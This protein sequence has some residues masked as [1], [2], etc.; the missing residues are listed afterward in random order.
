MVRK[1]RKACD[2]GQ[3]PRLPRG[4]SAVARPWLRPCQ[5]GEGP[6]RARRSRVTC[7]ISPFSTAA[8]SRMG[9]RVDPRLW[10]GAR[11]RLPG[12]PGW[13]CGRAGDT[14]GARAATRA[15]H[16]AMLGA[17]PWARHLLI[18]REGDRREF[19]HC[20]AVGDAR[21]ALKRTPGT[22]PV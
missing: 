3:V 2:R 7:R 6:G 11:L 9:R 8:R 16:R 17:S 20:D 18:V 19:D 12:A 15:Y 14:V 1:H 5:P 10:H 13:S 21:A 4:S 22:R